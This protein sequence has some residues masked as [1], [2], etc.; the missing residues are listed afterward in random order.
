MDLA[1]LPLSSM[2]Q[3]MKERAEKTNA[4]DETFMPSMNVSSLALVFSTL[5]FIDCNMELPVSSL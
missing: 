1:Q 4:R 2:L 3:F 5:S